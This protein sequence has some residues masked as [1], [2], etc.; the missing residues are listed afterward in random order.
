[1]VYKW[2]WW[3]TWADEPD[4]DHTSSIGNMYSCDNNWLWSPNKISLDLNIHK[5]KFIFHISV[6]QAY[7]TPCS[8]IPLNFGNLQNDLHMADIVPI[9]N[10]IKQLLEY[11]E[12]DCGIFIWNCKPSPN[13]QLI[14]IA[15]TIMN[16]LIFLSKLICKLPTQNESGLHSKFYYIVILLYYWL[17]N[18]YIGSWIM[19]SLPSIH[20]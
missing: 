14:I 8:R 17:I 13:G 6:M 9:N 15:T 18:S 4:D 16:Q 10:F 5:G 1:M 2:V 11:L 7:L 12:H 20:T 3:I 19:P